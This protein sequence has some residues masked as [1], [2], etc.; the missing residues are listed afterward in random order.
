[1]KYGYI[2]T[3]LLFLIN[4]NITVVDI[5]PDFIGI[6]LILHGLEPARA[7]SPDLE[8]AIQRFQYL[9]RISVAKLCCVP[10]LTLISGSENALVLA[11]T[12]AFSILE[13]IFMLYAFSALFTSFSSLGTRFGC[14]SINRGLPWIRLQTV[15]FT[16][17][18]SFF[19]ILPELSRLPSS[20]EG[21]IDS[22]T[23]ANVNPFAA[24]K[25]LLYACDL[26]FV[27][28]AGIIFIAMWTS[29][30]KKIRKDSTFTSALQEA[31]L[32][33]SNDRRPFF[34]R[35]AA[36]ELHFFCIGC[37]LTASFVVDGVNL[38]PAFAGGLFLIGSFTVLGRMQPDMKSIRIPA[39]AFTVLS[40]ISFLSSLLFSKK[41]Y[42]S[43]SSAGL[44]AVQGASGWFFLN[45]GISILCAALFLV[46]VF[47]F[48][49]H[50]DLF[51]HA[52]CG[53]QAEHEFIRLQEK[54]ERSR[55]RCRN[56][57]R[58]GAVGAVITALLGIM[59]QA[60]MFVPDPV[61]YLNPQYPITICLWII[62]LLVDIA[63]ILYLFYTCGEIRDLVNERYYID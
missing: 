48:L 60:L 12:F 9:F 2:L 35:T 62:V 54:T 58:F 30:L 22:V 1:M 38:I 37:A 43:C 18:R 51:L 27:L 59:R 28:I 20:D 44:S 42:E 34:R 7:V 23:E 45:L 39:V 56:L 21:Y 36:S 49:R 5:F 52:H 6:F 3:G 26:F 50:M 19:A 41:Y 16:A 17:F 8:D 15:I 46:I 40:A 11:I 29:F 55:I 25:T 10:L 63:W 24:Y 32:E 47:R 33:D 14:K 53:I 4:P 13:L 57:L 61:I 31:I